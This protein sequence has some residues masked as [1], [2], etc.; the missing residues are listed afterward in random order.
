MWGINHLVFK[1]SAITLSS[2]DTTSRHTNWTQ[3]SLIYGMGRL[4]K[5]FK[6]G[7]ANDILHLRFGINGKRIKGKY[8]LNLQLIMKSLKMHGLMDSYTFALKYNAIDT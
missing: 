6:R 1:I 8:L 3:L 5:D 4:K 2:G 7:K